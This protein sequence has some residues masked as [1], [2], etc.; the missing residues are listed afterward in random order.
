M[1]VYK[2]SAIEEPTRLWPQ[3]VDAPEEVLHPVLLV[4]QN[5]VVDGDHLSGQVVRLFDRAHD[6]NR[7]RVALPKLLHTGHDRGGGRAVA[8]A[9]VG[10]DDQNFRDSRS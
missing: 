8:A 7:V 10:R 3:A 4:P 9:R 2:R 5:P 1:Y 6:A